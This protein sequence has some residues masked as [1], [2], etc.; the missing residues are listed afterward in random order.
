MCARLYPLHLSL[1]DGL[2]LKPGV[3]PA[4]AGVSSGP[5]GA[6]ARCGLSEAVEEGHLLCQ[7]EGGEVR[8][9]GEEQPAL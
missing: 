6:L 3:G 5:L 8:L 4:L 7:G 2:S 1:G 9:V